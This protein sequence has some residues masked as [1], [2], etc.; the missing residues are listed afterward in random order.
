MRYAIGAGGWPVGQYL[1]PAGTLI[2]TSATDDWS[3]LA[4]SINSRG[5][6]WDR[7]IGHTPPMN[8][9]ALDQAA[10]NAMASAYPGYRHLLL[11]G[12]GVNRT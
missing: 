10:W 7:V 5:D 2:D 12:P 8:A 9:V 3:R 11:N 1:I 6:P 4:A